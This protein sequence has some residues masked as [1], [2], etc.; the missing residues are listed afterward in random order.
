MVD[1]KRGGIFAHRAQNPDIL[2]AKKK[3]AAETDEQLK[4]IKDEIV[5]I[6]NH[7]IERKELVEVLQ[8]QIDKNYRTIIGTLDHDASRE[9]SI[10]KDLQKRIDDLEI[11]MHSLKTSENS[12]KAFYLLLEGESRGIKSP[13][14]LKAENKLK[15][16]PDLR[17]MTMAQMQARYNL[18][19]VTDLD[20]KDE[21]GK[22]VWP[23]PKLQETE[24]EL[25][26]GFWNEARAFKEHWKT[27][28]A[29]DLMGLP[30]EKERYLVAPEI[31]CS[32]VTREQHY[33][34]LKA[35]LA[36]D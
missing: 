10:I 18:D 22:L 14:V 35:W 11:E 6:K 7:I 25:K 27:L 32:A 21:E 28:T 29:E 16:Y 17:N 31:K 2:A 13:E 30:S 4:G 9:Q 36:L 15:V 3:R 26:R 8:H 24:K 20:A 23:V 5:N 12:L 19:N 34:R 33:A 1:S